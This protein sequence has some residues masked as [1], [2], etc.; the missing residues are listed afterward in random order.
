M[1]EYCKYN[2]HSW[3]MCVW[4][5]VYVCMYVCMCVCMYVC[6]YVSMC[7]YVFVCIPVGFFFIHLFIFIFRGVAGWGF[8]TTIYLCF[9]AQWWDMGFRSSNVLILNKRGQDRTALNLHSS[10]FTLNTLNWKF[11]SFSHSNGFY[12]MVEWSILTSH[13]GTLTKQLV[14]KTSNI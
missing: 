1:L 11:C 14:H 2:R 7:V 3:C 9:T 10:I 13:Q 6:M 4:M 5:C 12:F 8:L